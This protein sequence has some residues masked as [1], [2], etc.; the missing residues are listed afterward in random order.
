MTRAVPA[1]EYP[2]PKPTPNADQ[3]DVDISATALDRLLGDPYQFFAQKIMGL[4]DLDALDADPNPL[5]QGN[6]AHEI[7]ERWHKAKKEDPAA[8]IAPIM[9]QVLDEENAD[10]LI[11]GLWQPRSNTGRAVLAGLTEG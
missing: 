7:L 8:R 11:R 5:W 2:R 1:P 9:E 10:P 6:V 4:S 3:R